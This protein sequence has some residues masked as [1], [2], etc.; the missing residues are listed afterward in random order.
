MQRRLAVARLEQRGRLQLAPVCGVEDVRARQVVCLLEGDDSIGAGRAHGKRDARHAEVQSDQRAQEHLDLI[1]ARAGGDAVGAHGE[2]ARGVLPEQTIGSRQADLDAEPTNAGDGHA[3]GGQLAVGGDLHLTDLAAMGDLGD[4][5]PSIRIRRDGDVHGDR[6]PERHPQHLDANDGLH[7][8][9][10]GG[11]AGTV[12]EDR[13]D[14]AAPG[15]RERGCVLPRGIGGGAGDGNTVERDRHRLTGDYR[16]DGAG[17]GDRLTVV[18]RS[19]AQRT[20]DAGREGCWSCPDH[21]QGGGQK[22]GG[23]DVLTA[24]VCAPGVNLLHASSFCQ[25]GSAGRD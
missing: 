1:A 5:G 14:R 12:R 7:A 4:D 9:N 20:G 23:H 24:P 11:A 25:D 3:H 21:D 6:T 8:Q 16:V 18:D 19:G 13:G 17:H 2:L 10:E 15:G 22:C